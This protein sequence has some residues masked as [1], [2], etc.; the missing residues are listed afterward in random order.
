MKQGVARLPPQPPTPRLT[1]TKRR[2]RA[3]VVCLSEHLGELEPGKRRDDLGDEVGDDAAEVTL[4]VLVV[5][6]EDGHLV[7]E[8]EDLDG[9]VTPAALDTLQLALAGQ[10]VR[11]AVGE[12]V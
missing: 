6:R 2:R 9:G 12:D 10:H 1:P 5:L 4:V 11:L 7:L 8:E 3:K